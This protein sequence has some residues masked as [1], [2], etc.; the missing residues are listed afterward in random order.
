M[1]CTVIRKEGPKI[2]ESEQVSRQKCCHGLYKINKIKNS[3]IFTRK[4]LKMDI[5]AII[6]FKKGY[7][8][9]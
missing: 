9:L 5:L 2:L 8:T 4:E 6:G 7:K 3:L 1:K